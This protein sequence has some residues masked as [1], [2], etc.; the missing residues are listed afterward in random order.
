[1]SLND[2]S[3]FNEEVSNDSI[4]NEEGLMKIER[5]LTLDNERNS[6]VGANEQYND[7]DKSYDSKSSDYFNIPP[8]D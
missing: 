8:E 3:K 4:Q 6:G 1:M 2:T 5:T 7:F